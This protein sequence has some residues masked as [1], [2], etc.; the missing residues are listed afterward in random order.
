MTIIGHGFIPLNREHDGTVPTT[1][2]LQR[3]RA[4]IAERCPIRRDH[5]TGAGRECGGA[6]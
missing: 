3:E 4:K 5:K 1:R 2:A 6:H